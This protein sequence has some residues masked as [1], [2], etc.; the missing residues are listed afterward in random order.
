[1]L[2]AAAAALVAAGAAQADT[3]ISNG[4]G[5]AID[6][7]GSGDITIDTSG[8]VVISTANTAPVTINSNN[9]VSNNGAI[10]NAGVDSAIGVEI[11]TTAAS[12]TSSSGFTSTG[13]IDLSGD[14]TA[15]RGI[16]ITGGH[17]FYGPITL[18]S[19]T[20]V[21]DTGSAG[22]VQASTLTLTG[23]SSAAFVLDQGTTVTSNI[24][25]AGSGI[26]QSGSNNST[27]TGSVI[28]YLNGTVNGNFINAAPISGVGASMTGIE[29]LGGIHACSSDTNAPSGFSCPTSS[30]GSFVNAGNIQLVGLY[31]P[32]SRGGNVE[33]GSAV[34]IGSS[35]D[36]GFVNSGPATSSNVTASV[37]SS[38]GIVSSST[39]GSVF[40]PTL[41]IDPTF[42][43][44]NTS[45][46]TPRGPAILGPVTADI[47]NADAGYSFINRGT[48]SAQA[49]D[50]QLNAESVVIEGN[51]SIYY[52]CLSS[53][54]GSCDTAAHTVSQ[55]VTDSNGVTRT[56]TYNAVGGLLNTGTI[57]AASITNL[58]TSSSVSAVA[59][60]IGDYA[61]VPNISVKAETISGSTTTPGIITAG[62]SGT[63][64]GSA[65]AVSISKQAVVNEIDVGQGASIVA[66]VQTNTISPDKDIANST[67]PFSLVAE[68]IIDRSGT[69]KTIN[70]AGTIQ[71]TVTTLVPQAGATTVSV[72]RAIDMQAA[73]SGTTTINNTGRILGDVFFAPAGGNNVLNVGNVGTAASDFVASNSSANYA[74]LAQ[75]IISQVSGYAPSTNAAYVDF[76]DGTGN[77][78]NVGSFGYVNADIHG[79]ANGLDVNVAANG[80]LFIASNTLSAPNETNT[81]NVRDLTVAENGTLG[82]SITQT[83]LSSLTP[84]VQA[85]GDVQLSGAT[86]AIQ[87]GSYVSSS[88]GTVQAPE[89]QTIT[90]IRT[91]GTLTDTTLADQNARL[92]QDTPFLF[93]SP[94]GSGAVQAAS[95]G[96]YKADNGPTPL[97]LGTDS[98]GQQVL[99]LTLKPR[100]IGATNADGSPGLN[101]SGEA[102]REFPFVTNA[103]A[104]DPELGGA[105]ATSMTIYNTPGQ[106]S[107]GINVKASQQQAQRV[108]SQFAPDVS[109]GMREVAI[110]LTDQAT[111]PVAARQRLLRSYGTV[112]GDM[113]LW[114]EEFT[115]HIN[116]KGRVSGDNSLTS[117]KDHGFGFTVGVDS[118]GPRTGWYG[119]AFTFY[120]GDVD[121]LLP[122]ATRTESE[123]YMLTGY[124]DWHGKH[125]FLDTQLSVAYGDF[126]ETRSIAV[127]NVV[128]NAVSKRPGVMLAG[129]V[130]MGVIGH[131]L[132]GIELDPHVSLD[133]LTLREEGYTENSGGAGFNLAVAPYFANS[134]RTAIG[135]DIKGTVTVFGVGL[136]PEAR[137]G[138][139]Y[140]LLHQPVKIRAGFDSTGGLGQAGNTMI[141]TGPDPDSGNVYG[142]LSLNAGTDTWSVGI[143][144][145]WVR[146]D[147]GSTT[148]VG[149]VT[150]LGRI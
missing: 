145:D 38:S 65:A 97:S 52:T 143:N 82:L 49:L 9:S 132:G 11:D 111:G 25:L 135:T 109:G 78:L 66:N 81:L 57:S 123:W 106:P 101:L 150:V 108:F 19:L 39:S 15:K 136:T 12:L 6:T 121:Q 99:L 16:W 147:N 29:V 43:P 32:N 42:A 21:T 76:G 116:N 138:Y 3:E 73:P 104:T 77:V 67:T 131:I 37:I 40:T 17:T 55:D 75:S 22:I 130:N 92:G 93:E 146:G 124:T 122:R 140:D 107:S 24:L 89:E 113:T 2:S 27:N 54:A 88:K 139:R 137:V 5:K 85:G 60:Q 64:G 23:D 128:R 125:V 149:T 70:N 10:G 13:T 48:I 142:G 44:A 94:A 1:M 119:G 18:T 30:G 36:G 100:S 14:G 61:T 41:V 31:Y 117:F 71:A 83:N 80:Q 103:L 53:V 110:M 59:L 74:I 141:F 96:S 91:S 79:V 51:S 98:S 4:T 20:G 56:V 62:V 118:G 114:G 28:V 115:G 8:S 86:L 95:D 58:D 72:T 69:V 129:G 33:S 34:V 35:I 102:A 26:T 133:G 90:L 46:T 45:T 144:Y 105:V 68:A 120:S 47:D 127:G 134:L 112:A 126:D 50:P 7:T 87:F 63:G 84:V 148:Q